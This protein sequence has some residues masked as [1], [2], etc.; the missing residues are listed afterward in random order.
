MTLLKLLLKLIYFSV[1]FGNF[2]VLIE[3]FNFFEFLLNFN[4]SFVE[5]FLFRL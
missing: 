1:Y 2:G 5:N 3:L 4:K